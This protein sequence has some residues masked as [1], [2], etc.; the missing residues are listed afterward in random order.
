MNDLHKNTCTC[1]FGASKEEKLSEGITEKYTSLIML[2][3]TV[4]KVQTH[5]RFFSLKFPGEMAEFTSPTLLPVPVQ[6]QK[7]GILVSF[8]H[9]NE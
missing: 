6:N 9:P 3:Y 4:C 7:S 8:S 1:F 5:K 2:R